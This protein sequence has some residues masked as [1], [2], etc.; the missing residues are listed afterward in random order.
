VSES[1]GLYVGE[2]FVAESVLMGY[3]TALRSRSRKILS[4]IPHCVKFIRAIRNLIS[5]HNNDIL[6][7][8]SYKENNEKSIIT[9]SGNVQYNS[10]SYGPISVIEMDALTQHDITVI[11]VGCIISAIHLILEYCSHSCNTPG[12]FETMVDELASILE[13]P[14][15]GTLMKDFPV[16]YS[17][18][19]VEVDSLPQKLREDLPEILLILQSTNHVLGI[20]KDMKRRG[21]G[22]KPPLLR[23]RNLTRVRLSS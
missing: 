10:P 8:I 21:F 13:I 17:I 11:E 15:D 22:E 6:S 14:S 7:S 18:K 20:V 5:T 3:G 16:D 12:E 4:M 19:Q 23:E 1:D 9:D 2:K